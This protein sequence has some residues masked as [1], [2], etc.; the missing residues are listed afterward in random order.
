MRAGDEHAA[1]SAGGAVSAPAHVTALLR[2][3]AAAGAEVALDVAGPTGSVQRRRLRPLSVEVGRLRALDVARQSELTIA[4]HRIAS[5]A[6][7]PGATR[8][9][10]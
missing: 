3:A 10:S 1:A 4:V 5:V 2:D 9:T 8:G 6:T 7:I